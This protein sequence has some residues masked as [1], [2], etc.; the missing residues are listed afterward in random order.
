M[1]SNARMMKDLLGSCRKTTTQRFNEINAFKKV[2]TQQ[3]SFKDW[4][5]E[6]QN[7]P[8]NFDSFVL[9]QPTIMLGKGKESACTTEVLRKLS[10]QKAGDLGKSKWAIVYDKR[11][12]QYADKV[13]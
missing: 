11:N 2:L 9:N 7:K 10:I 4:G 3:K 8:V 1:R 13:F 12:S 6:V 5:L